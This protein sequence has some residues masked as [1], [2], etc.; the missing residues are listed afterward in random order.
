MS[1]GKIYDGIHNDP[2]G[3][4]NATGNI[5]RDA[6]MFGFIPEDETCEGWSL[7]RIQELYDRVSK[8]WEPYAHIPSRLPPELQEKHQRI[9][10]AAVEHARSLGWDPDDEIADE[11]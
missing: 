2:R 10:A 3:A 6:W 11:A 8:A 9:Y 5:I 7:Q 1:S 4:M